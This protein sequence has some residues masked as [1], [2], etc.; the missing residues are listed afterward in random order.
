MCARTSGCNM[1]QPYCA[2]AHSRKCFM[3]V[4]ARRMS[5]KLRQSVEAQT[6]TQ[7]RDQ[8]EI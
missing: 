8:A 7:A 1:R 4:L 3:Q 6:G 2:H 5:M